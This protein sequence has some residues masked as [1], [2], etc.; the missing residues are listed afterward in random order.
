[1]SDFCAACRSVFVRALEN[2]DVR[3]DGSRFSA[4]LLYWSRAQVRVGAETGCRF[5]LWIWKSFNTAY[6]AEFPP[7]QVIIW[8]IEMGHRGA[9]AQLSF[10]RFSP[11]RI[12]S[13]RDIK[14]KLIAASGMY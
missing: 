12:Y 11:D 10:T 7:G 5:C 3:D 14:I 4:G 8:G 13:E 1:M 6:G 2:S 9:L